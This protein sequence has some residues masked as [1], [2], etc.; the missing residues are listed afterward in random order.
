VVLHEAAP[1]ATPTR[2]RRRSPRRKRFAKEPHRITQTF[3]DR[4]QEQL[5]VSHAGQVW[6]L[7]DFSRKLLPVFGKMRGLWRCHLIMA[8]ALQHLA[9]NRQEHAGAVLSLGLQAVHQAAIDRGD[10]STSTLLLPW[11]DPLSRQV[12]GA[13]E[14]E[15][16][17]IHAYR[18]ALRELQTRHGMK[19]H[20]IEE[21]EIEDAVEKAAAGKRAGRKA[22][23]SDK[24]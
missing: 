3:L 16:E 21:E 13:G 6:L 19:A 8:E 18:K 24:K 2:T 20:G 23:K 15:L 9:E 5:G 1:T 4:V 22:N 12:F 10:W 7:R 17:E 14:R 11:E